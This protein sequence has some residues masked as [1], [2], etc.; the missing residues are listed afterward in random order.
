MQTSTSRENTDYTRIYERPF[1]M[2]L[3]VVLAATKPNVNYDGIVSIIWDEHHR[4]YWSE[5]M[6]ERHVDDDDDDDGDD[7]DATEPSRGDR[8]ESQ[9]IPIEVVD[10]LRRGIWIRFTS[11]Q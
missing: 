9:L 1:G 3:V 7:G 11:S 5:N 6:L 4:F 2:Q 10:E 8:W